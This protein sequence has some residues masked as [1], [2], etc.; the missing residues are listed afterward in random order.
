MSTTKDDIR[1][2]LERGRANGARWLIVV[3]D[4]FSYEDY[5]VTVKA[6]EPFWDVYAKNNGPNMTRVMEVYDLD[7]PWDAQLDQRRAYSVPPRP[8]RGLS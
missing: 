5:P 8:A 4:T 2:W 3:C 6:D 7:M 1:R